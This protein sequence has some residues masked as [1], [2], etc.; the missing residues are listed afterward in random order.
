[1]KKRWIVALF[2][3]VLILW[4]IAGLTDFYQV[5]RFEKPV[6]CVLTDGK[7]DGGSG[8][9]RGLGYAFA[10]EGNFMPEDEFPGVTRFQAKLFGMP[11]KEE[12]R[13]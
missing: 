1:M 7:K 5:S 12:V 2:V 8:Y 6:F 11:F 4:L 10:I 13:D 3:A 9:Y